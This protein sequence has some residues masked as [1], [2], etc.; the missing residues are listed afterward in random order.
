MWPMIKFSIATHV[1]LVKEECCEHVRV[2]SIFVLQRLATRYL[3][4]NIKQGHHF[5]QH[6]ARVANELLY[7]LPRMHAFPPH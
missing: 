2:I 6:S 7:T 5:T 1:F 3:D 4:V